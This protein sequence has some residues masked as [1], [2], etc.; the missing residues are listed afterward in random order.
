[1]LLTAMA[2]TMIITAPNAIETVSFADKTAC[3][4]AAEK[5][6][7]QFLRPREKLRHHAECM[8]N[9]EMQEA[10]ANQND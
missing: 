6:N 3:Q 5:Y 1:M 7:D 8:S 2:W 9:D 10:N 4:V